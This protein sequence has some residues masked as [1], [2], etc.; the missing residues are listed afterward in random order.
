MD[1]VMDWWF[2]GWN[3]VNVSRPLELFARS[4]KFPVIGSFSARPDRRH[5]ISGEDGQQLFQSGCTR[6]FLPHPVNIDQ[7]LQDLGQ[8]RQMLRSGQSTW[9]GRHLDN[10]PIY[11]QSSTLFSLLTLLRYS[12]Y[13]TL[14]EHIPILPS[15][16]YRNLLFYLFS[17]R[18]N[19]VVASI[20][21]SISV[22]HAPSP[23]IVKC[24]V[25]WIRHFYSTI[26]NFFF[27][28]LVWLFFYQRFVTL[29][30]PGTER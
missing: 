4:T 22:S 13:G 15:G 5:R 19:R 27:S 2:S 11:F 8:F 1:P 7:S 14:L 17:P 30:L 25:S 6:C 24:P 12:N 10:L 21:D 23:G 18:L 20:L 28:M 9:Q 3:R 26:H 29:L 16:T